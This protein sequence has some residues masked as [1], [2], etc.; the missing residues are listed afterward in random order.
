MSDLT[1]I[2]DR[3]NL[4]VRMESKSI[5]VQRPDSP[6]ER[7]P[8]AMLREVVVLGSPMISCD[9]WRALAQE[10]IPAIL[11][12][13]RGG[14]VPAFMGAGLSATVYR[15]I[16]QHLAANDPATSMAIARWLI[17]R[18]MKGQELLF[19][20]F[21]QNS[22]NQNP[23]WEKIKR[24]R[25]LLREAN[26]LYSLMGHEGAAASEYFAGLSRIIHPKWRF[27]GRNRRPPKDP[28]NALLSL[29]YVL[30][31]GDVRQIV[32]QKGLDPALGFIHTPQPN[33]ESLVLDLLE[34]LR[35]EV[36]RFVLELIKKDINLK[37]FT[38]N[39]QDG[40]LLNKTG[41]EVFFKAWS[42]WK[43]HENA[44]DTLQS[45]A[46]R[47]VRKLIEFFPT[48]ETRTTG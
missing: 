18:K 40:C 45:K 32:Q 1:L 31:G 44:R 13:L 46:D 35:P 14:G 41:R 25:G 19:R 23:N 30:A 38:T 39:K 48:N 15:R 5:R 28:V 20:E 42:L 7:I 33:R 21:G 3:K 37:H 24:Y 16:G 47:I 2:L 36:D 9:V 6:P 8:L 43:S 11:L 12:P 27:T 26:D 4:V 22:S 29:S 34:P 17:D 10:N